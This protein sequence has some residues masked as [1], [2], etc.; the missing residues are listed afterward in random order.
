MSI[1]AGIPWNPFD[2]CTQ[3][4]VA[5]MAIC[6]ANTVMDTFSLKILFTSMVTMETNAMVVLVVVM[7]VVCT[8]KQTSMFLHNAY[9]VPCLS[10]HSYSKGVRLVLYHR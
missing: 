9:S 10:I 6:Y 3:L 8:Y 5:S 4:L 1:K 7:M 2:L